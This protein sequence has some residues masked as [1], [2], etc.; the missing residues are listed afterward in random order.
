MKNWSNILLISF[1]CMACTNPQN[2]ETSSK[3]D[4]YQDSMVKGNFDEV[5]VVQVQPAD[6]DSALVPLGVPLPHQKRQEAYH[7][8]YEGKSF[9]ESHRKERDSIF[10]NPTSRFRRTDSLI[11]AKRRELQIEDSLKRLK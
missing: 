4:V 11:A 8:K 6:S 9:D 7:P 2:H 10:R 3:Q 5:S 1:V